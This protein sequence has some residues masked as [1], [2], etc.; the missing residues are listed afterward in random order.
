MT[1]RSIPEAIAQRVLNP[2]LTPPL[3]SCF[4]RVMKI[5][6]FLFCLLSFSTGLAGT[7]S[8]LLIQ[9]PDRLYFIPGA[10]GARYVVRATR[11]ETLESLKKLKNLDFFQG[12][13]ELTDREL[14]LDSIDFV[15]LH[16]LLGA[17]ASNDGLM[18]FHDYSQV[19]IYHSFID[20]NA[21]KLSLQYSIAPSS[22]K[23]WR[24]FF[25]DS[26]SVAAGSLIL[27][28]GNTR[29]V[30]KLYDV[31]SGEVSKTVELTRLYQQQ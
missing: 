21:Q 23:D 31:N 13:G 29:A 20:S 17:W 18:N 30:L 27:T 4:L 2:Y 19:T 11:T 26:N 15:G 14:L 9:A 8:G 3:K 1:L 10:G 28:D 6:A 16:R 25:T 7:V 5:L 22:G 12:Q 24:I